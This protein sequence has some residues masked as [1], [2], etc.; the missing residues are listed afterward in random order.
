LNYK[1]DVDLNKKLEGWE[2]FYNF[3][4]PHKSLKGKIHYES[5]REK[6]INGSF[7]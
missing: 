7:L 6:I 1:D 2:K 5:L 4:R 3:D